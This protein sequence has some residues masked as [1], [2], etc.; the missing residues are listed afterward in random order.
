MS[1]DKLKKILWIFPILAGMFWG[2]AG[3]FTRTF[4][5]YGFDNITI[6]FVRALFATVILLIC[7]AFFDRTLLKIKLKEIKK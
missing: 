6:V 1:N 3:L 5:A 4:T 2:S 7:I